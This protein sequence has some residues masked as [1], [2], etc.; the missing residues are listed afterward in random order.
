V[1]GDRVLPGAIPMEGMNL[2]IHLRSLPVMPIPDSPN[3][4]ASLAMAVR[5]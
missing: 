3:V 4:P 5:R 1:I 2:V